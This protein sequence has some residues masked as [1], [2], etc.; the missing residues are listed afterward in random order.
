MAN[1]LPIDKLNNLQTDI[2]EIFSKE[3][4]TEADKEEIEDS[5]LDL[6]IMAYMYGWTSAS[7][8]LDTE[9]IPDTNKVDESV[10]KQIA[11]KNWKDRVGEYLQNGTAEEI[12]RVAD[13][14]MVRIYNESKLDFA[15]GCEF[16]VYKTW[17]TQLDDKVRDTHFYLEGVKVEVGDRFYTFDGD[18]ALAPGGFSL[19]QNN[20]N[21]RCTLEL[22]RD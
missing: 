12:L 1:L 8:E 3:N 21:C 15:E 17:G 2:T 18:S 14:E 13:T 11:G 7:D 22:S 10:N 4:I 6:L 19:V 9:I 16:A 5:V 20:V